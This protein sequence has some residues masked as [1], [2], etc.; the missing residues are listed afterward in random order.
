L[1]IAL[2][3]P[4]DRREDSMRAFRPLLGLAFLAYAVLLTVLL[5]TPN[6]A[7]VV[8]LQ[9]IP[10]F[11]WGDIGIHFTAFTV[12]SVLL[13]AARWPRRPGWA[14]VLLLVAYGVTTESLQAFVPHRS[15]EFLDYTENILGVVAGS[16]F[17]WLAWR[18]LVGTEPH[19]AR[20]LIRPMLTGPR[21]E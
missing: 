10:T 9:R 7:A 21:A 14:L 5:L 16:S 2:L 8:G 4:L 12:L 19:L 18:I 11:P 3:Y 1:D 13:H 20:E 15:V 17:Y 6:P